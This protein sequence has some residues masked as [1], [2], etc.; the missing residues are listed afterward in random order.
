MAHL[1]TVSRKKFVAAARAA[2]SGRVRSGSGAAGGA[3]G[4]VN[5]GKKHGV[6]SQSTGGITQSDR[7]VNKQKMHNSDGKGY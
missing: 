4:P 7:L 6:G 3:G 5:S 2:H 1:T